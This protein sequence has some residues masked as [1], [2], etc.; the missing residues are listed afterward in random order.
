MDPD[1]NNP[2]QTD[3]IN[4]PEE[5]LPV[6][7][8]TLDEVREGIT[9]DEL[10]GDV[11]MRTIAREFRNGFEF[12]KQKGKS[13]TFF[14]SARFGEHNPHYQA[15]YNLAKRLSEELGYSVITGGGPGIMEAAN[16]GAYDA[17]GKSYGVCIKMPIGQAKN[18]YI[19]DSIDLYYFFTRKVMLSFAANA[20]IYCP[21]GFGT[22]DELFEILNL[23][24]THKIER[25]PI[26]LYGDGY[27]SE[28]QSY[29][30]EEL[31]QKYQTIDMSDT[32]L[33]T[34]TDSPDEVIEI[35]KNAPSR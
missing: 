19:T 13:V 18:P 5:R 21:G 14:G 17:G 26:I 32:S 9:I 15:A 23:V 12:L 24:Q 16:R 22:M 4:V 10:E 29:V 3:G 7:P 30:E 27:W 2:P 33:Y 31:K 8:L 1:T 28:F 25:V 35:L 11:R 6:K 20:Y 34:I